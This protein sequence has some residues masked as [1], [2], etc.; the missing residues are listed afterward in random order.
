MRRL[1]RRAAVCMAVVMAFCGIALAG[2]G[3]EIPPADET[4]SALYDLAVKENPTTLKDLLGFSSDDAVMEAFVEDVESFSFV[5]SLEEEFIASGIEFTDEELADMSSSLEGMLDKLSCTTEITD[6]SSDE[7]TVL[8]T[9]NGYAMTDIENA[10]LEVQE[11]MIA[12]MDEDT[13]MAIATGDTEATMNYMKEYMTA[14]IDKIVS[15]EPTQ[16]TQMEVVCE[17]LIAEGGGDEIVAWLPSDIGQ[18]ETELS[19]AIMK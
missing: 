2:C 11:E 17:R 7:T 8:L 18:F 10:A 12:G 3:K 6:E 4:V 5:A 14:Y 13:Q 16:E 9:T 15:L 1:G 19:N